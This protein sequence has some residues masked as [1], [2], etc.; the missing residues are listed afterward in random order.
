[1]ARIL[2]VKRLELFYK[3]FTRAS[4]TTQIHLSRMPDLRTPSFAQLKEAVRQR[5]EDRLGIRKP[6]ADWSVGDIADFRVDLEEVCKSSI[7]EKWFYT[8]FKNDSDKLPRIDVLNLLSEYAG[9][10]NWDAFTYESRPVR[11]R[12]KFAPWLAIFGGLIAAA[13]GLSLFLTKQSDQVKVVF[14]DAYTREAV[15]AEKLNF[16]TASGQEIKPNKQGEF[17]REALDSLW[18]DGPYFKTVY[19]QIPD[20]D[21]LR[22]NLYPDDYA[23]MLNFF[24]R[25]TTE[26]WERRR[27]QLMNAIHPEAKIFHSH[28][29]LSGIELLNREEFIYRLTLPINSLRNLEIQNIVYKDDKIYRLRFIQKDN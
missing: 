8:H 25:S 21:T 9:Y 14:T 18:V 6:F 29:Q 10:K 26:D 16:R 17:P 27:E 22:V 12:A 23:M 15:S 4:R 2:L 13:I 24:S 28:P 1:M 7:S 19:T 20:G 11:K 5:A 3:R